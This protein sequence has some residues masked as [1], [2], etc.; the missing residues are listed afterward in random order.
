MFHDWKIFPSFCHL[1]NH[2]WNK[3]YESFFNS[4]IYMLL[5]IH[6]V[7]WL[8][9]CLLFGAFSF[10]VNLP[11][12]N[13][14]IRLIHKKKFYL[15]LIVIPPDQMIKLINTYNQGRIT[16]IFV[17]DDSN[18]LF[19][20]SMETAY[21]LFAVNPPEQ[22]EDVDFYFIDET[23]SFQFLYNTMASKRSLWIWLL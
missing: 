3:K 20:V 8:K 10:L 2:Y 5:L 11:N 17:Q 6:L 9:P 14:T 15:S 12:I 13:L 22:I 1:P 21:I 4:M 7:G 19:S 16:I 18:Q 23:L